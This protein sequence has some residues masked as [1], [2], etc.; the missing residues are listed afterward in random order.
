MRFVICNFSVQ[1]IYEVIILKVG[2]FVVENYPFI[3]VQ[4]ERFEHPGITRGS[5]HL[6]EVVWGQEQL[7]ELVHNY[8][9]CL[10]DQ[11]STRF[12]IHHKARKE[13]PKVYRLKGGDLVPLRARETLDMAHPEATR[14]TSDRLRFEPAG[15]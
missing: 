6:A 11:P 8:G 12:L 10:G 4:F 15:K 7:R 1:I 3:T 14:R 9:D 5:F 2:G 13:A